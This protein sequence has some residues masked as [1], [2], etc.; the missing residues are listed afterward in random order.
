[1]YLAANLQIKVIFRRQAHTLLF[2]IFDSGPMVYNEKDHPQADIKWISSQNQSRFKL[3]DSLAQRPKSLSFWNEAPLFQSSAECE[4]VHINKFLIQKIE[5]AGKNR[6]I[7]YGSRQVVIVEGIYAESNFSIGQRVCIMPCLCCIQGDGKESNRMPEDGDMDITDLEAI[8]KKHFP[9]GLG[10]VVVF[11]VNNNKN[12]I[13]I[14]DDALT[15][16][17][18]CT[19]MDCIN[20]PL[21]KAN[22]ADFSFE[23]GHP[24]LILGIIIHELIQT[25]FVNRKTSFEFLT[26]EAKRLLKENVVTLYSCNISDRE[27]LNEILRN[28]KN[29]I[30]LINGGFNIENVEH[31]VYSSFYGLKGSIDCLDSKHVIEIKTGKHMSIQHR[32]Q[33]ILYTILILEQNLKKKSVDYSRFLC[34]ASMLSEST[35]TAHHLEKLSPLLYYVKQGDFVKINAEH[36]EIVHLMKIRNDI[37]CNKKITECTCPENFPCSILNKIQSLDPT[38]FLRK[39]YESIEREGTVERKYIKCTK[40]SQLKNKL[41]Y[42]TKEPLPPGEYCYIYTENTKYITSG[43]IEGCIDGQVTIELFDA[44]ELDRFILLCFENDNNFLKFMRWSLVQVA[45]FKYLRKEA[46][47]KGIDSF[48]LPGQIFGL[49]VALASSLDDVEMDSLDFDSNFSFSG[50]ST[51][52][53]E[54]PKRRTSGKISPCKRPAMNAVV[55]KTGKPESFDKLEIETLRQQEETSDFLFTDPS[56]DSLSSIENNRGLLDIFNSTDSSFSLENEKLRSDS[57]L[58][59]NFNDITS[60]PTKND[61]E[62]IETVKSTP[63]NNAPT[64]FE[65]KKP[66][67]L[68]NNFD[69]TDSFPYFTPQVKS[70]YGSFKFYIPDLFKGEFLKLNEDQKNALFSALNCE[71]YRIVHGMPGT[72]KST[73]IALLIRILIFYGQKVLFICYTHLAIQNVLN[74]IGSVNCYRAKK[75]ALAFNSYEEATRKFTKVDLVAG[76]CYS[77]NDPVFIKKKFDYCIID[78]GSQIHLLLSLIPISISDRFCIVG[79]HLQLKPL[80]RKGTE[81]SLSLFE[82]LMSN[83]SV[84][85]HQYRMGDSIMRLSNTLFYDNKLMGFGGHSTVEFIDSEGV[86]ALNFFK[87]LRNAVVLCY[88]N[89]KVRELQSINPELIITTIDRYQGSEAD[90]I[91]VVFDPVER[92]TVLESRE[93]LNVALTRARK[94]LIL[95]GNRHEMMKISLF[96]DL[97]DLL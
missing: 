5:E 19:A 66:K 93:R 2:N 15:V 95:L 22:I 30:K 39:Q 67:V 62:A 20:N 88:F 54:S 45:Y 21:I 31:K 85:T 42:K 17:S 94:K 77:F 52:C 81:L 34:D 86:D 55:S 10:D 92:C 79:D 68:F 9:N 26:A 61:T 58:S 36:E 41:V 56:N 83:C 37:T 60:T 14:E 25:A 46:H 57:E 89:N 78:E 90:E 4:A 47:G 24:S 23:Y 29:I 69:V 18:F 63:A 84:L 87:K 7:L 11:H 59:F 76:T 70:S 12:S 40:I 44:I 91:V 53:K 96:N 72:G 82:H 1:M 33:A 71:D 28:M 43:T 16:T 49:E 27:A 75:E 35:N 8:D 97:L 13:L 3:S 64:S 48:Q 51:D 73:V 6:K 65:L 74:K 38:H 50:T 32:S 80:C